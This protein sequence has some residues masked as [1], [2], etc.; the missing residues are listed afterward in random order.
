[1]SLDFSIYEFSIIGKS[2]E[3]LKRIAPS[4][5]RVGLIYNPDNPVDAV[6]FR[7]FETFAKQLAVQPIDLPI[8][9]LADLGRALEKLAE[10]A[11]GG[12]IVPPDVTAFILRD[13]LTTLAARYRLPAIYSNSGYVTIGALMSYGPDGVEIFRQAASYVDRVLRGEKPADL[14]IQQP[15]KLQLVI[16]LKTAKAL[17]LS[18]PEAVL[19]TA[20]EVIQ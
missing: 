18:I 7:S 16:N 10:Q 11:N 5:S 12:I 4:I 14:P 20:D 19:A 13:Q 6:Y 3:T 15:T 8:H 1:M 2:L 9:G 17:G